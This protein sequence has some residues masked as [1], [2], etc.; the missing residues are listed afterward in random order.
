MWSKVLISMFVVVMVYY[1]MRIKFGTAECWHIIEML[2]EVDNL[3]YSLR[4]IKQV[5]FSI[6]FIV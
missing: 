4:V 3:N 2:T 1:F 6:H 5:F